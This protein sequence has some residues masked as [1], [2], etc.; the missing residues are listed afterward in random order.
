MMTVK[1]AILAMMISSSTY[2]PLNMENINRQ[3]DY[4]KAQLE[5]VSETSIPS[6][7]EN[8]I[9]NEPDV[10]NINGE[11]AQKSNAVIGINQDKTYEQCMKE[12][13]ERIYEEVNRMLDTIP[14]HAQEQYQI[15]NLI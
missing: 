1:F 9:I 5:V 8:E 13:F 10:S 12:A 14:E 4:P 6:V 15:R 2:A 7:S 11:Y 3:I